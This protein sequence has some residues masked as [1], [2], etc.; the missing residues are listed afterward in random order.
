[1]NDSG[2]IQ[3]EFGNEFCIVLFLEYISPKLFAVC[4]QQGGK[5]EDICLDC[6]QKF[7][8]C[9]ISPVK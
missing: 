3:M 2:N 5:S 9:T 4:E 6:V 1:M 7:G 8:L